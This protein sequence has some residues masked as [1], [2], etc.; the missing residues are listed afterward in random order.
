MI[1][2]R[3]IIKENGTYELDLYDYDGIKV[4]VPALT[5]KNIDFIEGVIRLDSNYKNDSDI[6]KAPDPSQDLTVDFENIT[7][8]YIGSIAYWFGQMKQGEDFNKCL[9][10]VIVA[11]DRTNSTHLEASEDGRQTMFEIIVNKCQN[12]YDLMCELDKVNADGT[13]LPASL[14]IEMSN[15]IKASGKEGFWRNLSFASKFFAYADLNLNNKTRYSKYDNIVSNHLHYY[16]E[17]ILNDK[18]FITRHIKLNNKSSDDNILSV[19]NTYASY[20]GKIINEA[21]KNCT[22]NNLNRN[23]FDHL[24]WYGFK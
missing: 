5:S 22:V 21:N 19:Y 15:G 3:Y 11:I 2:K 9:K 14:I 13:V 23:T 6:N 16:V 7:N 24:V 10:G 18:A 17:I 1:D 20:I 8:K 12:V 4:D